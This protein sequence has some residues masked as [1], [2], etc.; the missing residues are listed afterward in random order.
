MADDGVTIRIDEALQ[1]RPEVAAKSSGETFE[2][3]VRHALEAFA[4]TATDWDEVERI[5]DET[6]EKGDGIPW[7][8]FSQ[9]LKT[10]GQR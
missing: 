10:L 9:R 5:C 4:D 8:D 6:L 2:Q 1:A 7:E 3:Y